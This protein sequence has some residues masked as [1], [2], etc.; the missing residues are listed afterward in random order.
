MCRKIL[1]ELNKVFEALTHYSSTA[2]SSSVGDS[3]A[4]SAIGTHPAIRRRVFR[5][6][7]FYIYTY[8]DMM[9]NFDLFLFLNGTKQDLTI[10]TKRHVKSVRVE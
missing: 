10:T 8:T 1:R 5:W 7:N 6:F 9:R 4:L 2:S 3:T